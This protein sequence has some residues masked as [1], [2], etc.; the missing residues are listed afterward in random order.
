MHSL[1]PWRSD[2]GNAI[3]LPGAILALASR[4]IPA[5]LYN[6][7]PASLY[8]A[9]PASLYIAALAHPC[10]SRHKAI[11]Y[12][13]APAIPGLSR[14]TVHPVHKKCRNWVAAK[15]E[16]KTMMLFRHRLG[17]MRLPGRPPDHPRPNRVKACAAGPRWMAA[18]PTPAPP[19]PSGCSGRRRSESSH[20][21]R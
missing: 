2:V 20:G 5:S 19:P 8:N 9:A 14:H 4:G 1:H 21:L 15:G 11:L 17:R 6:A 7:A 13:A 10:A 3:G 18:P 12:N 16:D